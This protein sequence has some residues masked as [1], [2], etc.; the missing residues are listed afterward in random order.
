VALLEV[1]WGRLEKLQYT[2]YPKELDGSEKQRSPLKSALKYS[3]CN[4]LQ[5]LSVSL[6][7]PT[8]QTQATQNVG[9]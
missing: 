9:H 3:L 7:A 6:G 8:E 2:P 1:S 5:K 4:P